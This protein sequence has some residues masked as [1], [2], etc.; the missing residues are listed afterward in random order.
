MARL[1]IT[2]SK[3]EFQGQLNR[4]RPARTG[5][6]AEAAGERSWT[7]RAASSRLERRSQI[8]TAAVGGVNVPIKDIE[9][10]SP[11]IERSLLANEARF[12]P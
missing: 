5:N 9:K 2:V 3:R 10:G 12:L 1:S 4:S 11:E 6:R 7:A 8:G